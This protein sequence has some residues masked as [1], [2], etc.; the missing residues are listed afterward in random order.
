[1]ARTAAQNKRMR[2][3]KRELIL[4]EAL[5]QFSL[6]GYN[7]TRIQDIA[8]AAKIAQGLLYYYYPSKEAIYVDLVDD[9]IERIN[10]TA[11]FVRDMNKPSG[12]KILSALR[13]LFKTIETSARFRQTCRMIAQVAYQADISEEAQAHLDKKRDI[14]YRIMAEIFRKGQLEG[15]VVDGDAMELSI[16][17]WTSING[18]AIYY[19]SRDIAV[20]LP[21]YRLVAP[22]FLKHSDRI[23]E[24]DLL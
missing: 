2:D 7:A 20:N 1:M 5:N 8:E 13:I 22:M 16:L 15:A 14:A 4:N 23:A 17:F 19:A 10:D 11:R 21:S 24:E 18:L 3:A 9:S 12:Q 6:K